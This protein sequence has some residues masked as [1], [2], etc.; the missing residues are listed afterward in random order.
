MIS[1]MKLAVLVAALGFSMSALAAEKQSEFSIAGSLSSLTSKPSGGASETTDMT[2]ISLA[3]GYYFTSQMVGQLNLN[4][5]SAG[6]GGATMTFTT[7]G[8]G[9]KYYFTRGGK[10]DIVPFVGA[11]LDLLSVSGPGFSGSGS[12][13]TGYVGASN[14]VSETA[15]LDL[16]FSA[17]AGS[18]TVS[19]STVDQTN[20]ILAVGFTQRF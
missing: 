15:S 11:R 16:T 10:G 8:V 20:T 13:I 4:Y 5:I 3:Y 12:Q 14:F 6:T 2:N 9:V 7:P 1:K 18:V 17:S 19:G